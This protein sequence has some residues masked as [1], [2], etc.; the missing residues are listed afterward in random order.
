MRVLEAEDGDAALEVLERHP[1][2]S[3]A[4]VLVDHVMPK[5]SGLDV[6]RE[7]RRRWPWIPV[8][9]ITA[10]GS[11]ELAVEAFRAG[12]CN[13]LKKPVGVNE[14]LGIVDW[15]MRAESASRPLPSPAAGADLLPTDT[16]HPNVARAIAFVREHFAESIGLAD[17]AR[18]AALSKFHLCRL[19]RQETGIS[20]RGY[21]R[22]LRIERAKVLLADRRVPVTEIAYGV[23]FNDVSRFDRNFERSV[24][25]SP[26]E[27]RKLLGSGTDGPSQAPG[28]RDDRK[29]PR[30]RSGGGRR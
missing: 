3:V 9:I 11:E 19:F 30:P 18:A 17:V 16:P 21:L 15:V 10:F 23:G 8:V 5:R 24:G 7:T 12:A 1:P 14:L 4:L 27:Y 26:T 6:L 22:A 25:I 20:F 2:H 29:R 28:V 13:Y